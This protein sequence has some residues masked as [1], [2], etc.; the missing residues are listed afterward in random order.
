MLQIEPH[1]VQLRFTAGSDCNKRDQTRHRR[2]EKLD[3]HSFELIV[4]GVIP[5]EAQSNPLFSA[6]SKMQSGYLEQINR[7]FTYPKKQM[8]WL[9]GE[10]SGV[11]ACVKSAESISTGKKKGNQNYQV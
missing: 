11:D 3:I 10:I 5:A 9:S 7:D 1:R 2:I 8:R 4:N 6:R